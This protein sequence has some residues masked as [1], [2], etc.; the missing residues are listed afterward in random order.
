MPAEQKQ[1]LPGEHPWIRRKAWFSKYHITVGIIENGTQ[2]RTRQF[3]GNPWDF[4]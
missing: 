2:H 3:I 1:L 4:R